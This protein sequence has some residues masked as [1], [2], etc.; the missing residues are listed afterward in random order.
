[1]IHSRPRVSMRPNTSADAIPDTPE[2]ANRIPTSA[3]FASSWRST[4]SGITIV[5]MPPAR[6]ITETD[7]PRP[8]SV[9]FFHT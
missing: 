2:I 6:L 4:S 5:V 3:S 8:R 9:R 1:M 7:T